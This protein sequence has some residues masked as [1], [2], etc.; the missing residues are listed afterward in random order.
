MTLRGHVKNGQIALDEPVQLPEGA[1]VN[2]ELVEKPSTQIARERR[3]RQYKAVEMPG[4]SLAHELIR[5]RR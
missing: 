2:V 4:G 5:D 3:E 1:Q